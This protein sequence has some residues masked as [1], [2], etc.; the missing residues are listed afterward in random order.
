MKVPKSRVCIGRLFHSVKADWR[1]VAL[2][3]ISLKDRQVWTCFY[4]CLIPHVRGTDCLRCC[5]VLCW[6]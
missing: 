1:G 4:K 6:P 3:G 5:F 2:G